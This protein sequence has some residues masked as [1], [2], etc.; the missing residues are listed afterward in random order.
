MS[1]TREE[2]TKYHIK[3]YIFL[4]FIKKKKSCCTILNFFSD[5]GLKYFFFIDNRDVDIKEKK[6]CYKHFC[7]C[8]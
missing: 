8:L 5:I 6:F 7:C 1:D 2:N 4:I 3:N